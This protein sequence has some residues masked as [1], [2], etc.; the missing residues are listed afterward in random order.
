[1]NSTEC[2]LQHEQSHGESQGISSAGLIPAVL[3]VA[4]LLVTV[5][6][7]V[8]AAAVCQCVHMCGAPQLDCFREFGDCWL[9]VNRFYEFNPLAAAH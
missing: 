8:D 9:S 4:A 7:A 3:L 5:D 6:A 2:R 1:M